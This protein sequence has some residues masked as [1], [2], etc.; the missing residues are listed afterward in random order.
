MF[1]PNVVLKY[2]ESH[3]HY[4]SNNIKT[5]LKHFLDGDFKIN[6]PDN[7]E[8]LIKIRYG[9][10]KIDISGESKK[11]SIEY[12]PNPKYNNNFL[13][14]PGY[15]LITI[16]VQGTADFVEKM[17]I[18]VYDRDS[19]GESIIRIIEHGDNDD[20]FYTNIT[21][22]QKFSS[23]NGLGRILTLYYNSDTINHFREH[24]LDFDVHKNLSEVGIH[25]DDSLSKSFSKEEER[26]PSSNMETVLTAYDE[27]ISKIKERNKSARLTLI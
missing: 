24:V 15:N 8:D 2:I 4:D 27:N 9:M 10:S 23:I 12:I 22:N 14:E 21:L 7:Y 19:S 17:V 1:E 26:S 6:I 20:I 3:Y 11:A 16:S 13:E 18:R 5:I 25:R